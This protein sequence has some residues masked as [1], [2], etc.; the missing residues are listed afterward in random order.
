MCGFCLKSSTNFLLFM[1]SILFSTEN[2]WKENGVNCATAKGKRQ[3]SRQ[4][5]HTN[6]KK[7]HYPKRLK[8]IRARIARK[9]RKIF[10]S[11]EKRIDFNDIGER[12]KK[13]Q[14]SHAK[15]ASMELPKTCSIAPNKYKCQNIK[16]MHIR[17]PK[18]NMC[19]D[20][21]A[22]TCH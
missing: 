6:K 4:N 21:R 13:Q 18:E 12:E 10:A 2:K 16:H 11:M 1:P 14:H 9:G 3:N 19:P 22:Q 7:I 8:K 5:S 17:H 20:N 15:F